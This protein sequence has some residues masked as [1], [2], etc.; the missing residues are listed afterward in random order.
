MFASLALTVISW[1]ALHG[2]LRWHQYENTNGGTGSSKRAP[3][4]RLAIF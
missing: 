1:W 4:F 2:W 3:L